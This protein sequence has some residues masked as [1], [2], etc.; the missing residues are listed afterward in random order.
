M[1]TSARL[2]EAIYGTP[3]HRDNQVVNSLVQG[4]DFYGNLLRSATVSNRKYFQL[5]IRNLT[6]TI[7]SRYY[8]SSGR[9]NDFEFAKWNV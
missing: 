2:R 8:R 5:Q 9:P 6:Q 3:S 7:N 1:N 4:L